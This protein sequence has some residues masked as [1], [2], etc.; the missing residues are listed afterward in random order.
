MIKISVILP[1]YGVAQ[2]IEKCTKSLLDQTLQD[3]EF[4]F[5]DDHGP[6]NSIELVQK[7]IENH[8]RKEQFVFLK[9]EH[10]LGAGMARNYAI[11]KA[12]GEFNTSVVG[13]VNMLELANRNGAKILQASTS[14]VYGDPFVHPRCVCGR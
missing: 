6:D 3:M 14:E 11:P 1:V 10:N 8:P 13:A 7:M 5:V 9:P 2:Y 4:I 12:K